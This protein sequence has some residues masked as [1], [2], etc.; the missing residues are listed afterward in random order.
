MELKLDFIAFLLIASITL[1][2]N[3][4]I[5]IGTTNPDPSAIL[6]IN[7]P[8]RGL[9]IPR[10]P[11]TS[12]LDTAT[13]NGIE[14]I[15]LLLYNTETIADVSPGFY[16][17]GGSSWIALNKTINPAWELIGNSGTNPAINFI[18]T[19]DAT[20]VVFRVNNTPIM[21]LN[22]N[23]QMLAS[24][25]GGNE[26]SPYYSFV[27]D[28]NT[29]IWTDGGDEF[30][31]GAGGQE[32]ITID[33][34][35]VEG[36]VIIFNEDS[37]AINFRIESNND[38]DLFY[39]DGENDIIY[40][41]AG[42]PYGPVDL[43][44]SHAGAGVFA[45]NGYTSGLGWGIYGENTSTTGGSYGGVA[46]SRDSDNGHGIGGIANGGTVITSLAGLSSGV[47]GNGAESGIFA[48]ATN[49]SGDRYGGYFVGGDLTLSNTPVAM[50]A[51]KDSG[52]P[53][54]EL[55]FGGYFD[56]NQD[57][58]GG[59]QDY[60][61]VGLSMGGTTYKI[62]GAGSVSTVVQDIKNNDR[63]MFCPEAPEILFQ[64]YGI[65][66]LINGRAKI[67]LDP[68]LTKNIQV[69][70]KHPLKVFIQLEGDSK[71][72]FVTD[73]SKSGFTVRE[74]QDGTSNTP[75][76]WQIVATRADSYDTKGILGSKH[77]NV[78]FP[79]GP[80]QLNILPTINHNKNKMK[81]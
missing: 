73:K 14:A 44:S 23:D 58:E 6:D 26:A 74:L 63:I 32:F 12:T 33:E 11:L 72:V 29:G 45:V 53:S 8:D 64:D 38:A 5:G 41:G 75:F 17:W 30:S 65:G 28:T 39:V 56:G 61:Y 24:T 55:T 50:L 7:S 79:E 21:R 31:L 4:Q 2:S 54:G 1:S 20:D 16:Y 46:V 18:G 9:L 52:G 40:V 78:R 43:F 22:T 71:G 81:K 62:L 42:S 48:M 3:A 77:E 15:G 80:G 25:T 69:D 19:S 36:D 60:A 67:T 27:D 66:K 37:D 57:N 76:A 70:K 59:T 35:A 34:G 51:A 47:V 68:I 13:I 49:N 10:I